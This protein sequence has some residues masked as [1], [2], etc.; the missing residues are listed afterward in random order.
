MKIPLRELE[1]VRN[2]PRAYLR[3]RE[4]PGGSDFY[5]KSKYLTLQ[6]AVFHYH[7]EKGDLD[8]ARKY[9]EDAHARQFKDQRSLQ[10]W[11]DQLNNYAAAFRRLG[12][13]VFK[14]RDQLKLSL[15][16]AISR[17]VSLTAQ[18]PRLDLTSKGYAV[19]LFS[20][21]PVD[22]RSELRLP[23]IQETYS[24]KLSAALDEITVGVYD[25]ATANYE[26]YSF[27]QRE[28]NRATDELGQLVD[29]LVSIA[30]PKTLREF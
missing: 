3:K 1:Q 19:W 9:L 21:V 12:N 5:G 22:L 24:K 27:S 10:G 8:S 6:R 17:E 14:V 23:L 25:F 29:R 18:I 2:D 20:K 7:E 11:L 15:P 28:V 16:E 26:S 13:S 4:R 30:R